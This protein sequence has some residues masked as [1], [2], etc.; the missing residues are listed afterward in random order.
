MTDIIPN[1]PVPG[2]EALPVANESR[3]QPKGLWVLVVTE[4]W[5]A[6]SL[7][8]MM[9]LLVIY[10][11]D[12]ILQ[13]QHIK[14]VLGIGPVIAFV[15]KLYAPVGV[16][17]LAGA[18]MGLF[19]A[20]IYGLPLLGS[21]LADRVLGR[22]R[23]ILLGALFMTLG[24]GL[25]SFDAS[26]VIALGLLL[27]G[28]ACC[29]CMKAQVGALYDQH[30]PRRSDAYQ[31]YSLGVQIAVIV[32]PLLCATLAAKAWH[33]GFLAA[34]V[35][36]SIG[37]ACYFAGRRWLPAEAPI[38]ATGRRTTKLTSLERKRVALLVVLAGVFAIGALPNEEIFNG[39]LLWANQHYQLTLAG[40]PFPVSALL[41]LDGLISTLAGLAVLWFWRFYERKYRVVPEIVKI[42]LGSAIV[43]FGPLSLALGSWLEP[44]LH[45]VSLW[46]GIVFHIVNDIGFSMV[47]AIG[48]TLFS[49]VAPA[50]VN[51]LLVSLFTLHL[52]VANLVIGKLA[53]LI[54]QM[55]DTAFWLL[56]AACALA[57]TLI[58]LVCAGVF[59][60]LLDPPSSSKA[61]PA[62]T[63][64]AAPLPADPA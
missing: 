12:Q 60:K 40:Y 23:T 4:A 54:T 26:F 1:A 35:G 31:I 24:H 20:L 16:T 2:Q 37:L 39:Y 43:T 30:D 36:M 57:A 10:M 38:P 21:W 48:M 13:P 45:G 32:S 47:Y 8:G 28:N 33:W 63:L 52:F 5:I 49:R 53:S 18:F 7:Y 17:A 11:R 15:H 62:E 19:T 64:P 14:H 46:W 61:P 50:S 59:R 29:G 25:M 56:H 41:S 6:F 3:G 22:T 42:A 58:F 9:A 51:T 44:A 55:P 34:G 27:L